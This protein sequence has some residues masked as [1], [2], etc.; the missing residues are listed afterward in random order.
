LV[1]LFDGTWAAGP[2]EVLLLPTELVSVRNGFVVGAESISDGI[3]A[4]DDRLV[5]ADEWGGCLGD[6][7]MGC[8]WLEG[9][10]CPPTLVC[11]DCDW[12]VEVV[13]P[14]DAEVSVNLAANVCVVVVVTILVALPAV[15]IA[16][17]YDM[18]VLVLLAAAAAAAAAARFSAIM[19]IVLRISTKIKDN[20]HVTYLHTNIT[21]QK[22]KYFYTRLMFAMFDVL[23]IVLHF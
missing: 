20:I 8:C 21:W 13:V 11:L 6:W 9:A 10:C 22:T 15:M 2:L 5:G 4:V 19:K 12:V 14:T 17:V 7:G 18:V 23:E 3:P 16:V 1:L